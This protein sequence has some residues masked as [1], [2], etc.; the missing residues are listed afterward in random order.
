MLA[1]NM[2][3]SVASICLSLPAEQTDYVYRSWHLLIWD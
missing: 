1:G 2:K 3:Q